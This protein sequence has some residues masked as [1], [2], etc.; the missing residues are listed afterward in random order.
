MQKIRR[1]IYSPLTLTRFVVGVGLVLFL[2]GVF[3]LQIGTAK[4]DIHVARSSFC[5]AGWVL[6]A[7]WLLK[8]IEDRQWPFQARHPRHFES[9]KRFF[10]NVLVIA[11]AVL[12][13]VIWRSYGSL[14]KDLRDFIPRSYTVSANAYAP[15]TSSASAAVV[16]PANVDVLPPMYRPLSL[17]G[18][19]SPQQVFVATPRGLPND[20]PIATGT[21]FP[22]SRASLQTS[23][24][25]HF[26]SAARTT[27]PIP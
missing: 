16:I 6:T 22:F 7:G 23:Q 5:L 18:Y 14:D 21:L 24:T 10:T 15:R 17:S 11:G 26:D 3:L 4:A 27:I 25:A 1:T 8:R 2:L 13:A 9:V 20:N 19:G 12:G